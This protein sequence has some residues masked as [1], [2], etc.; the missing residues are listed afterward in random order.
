MTFGTEEFTNEGHSTLVLDRVGLRDAPNLRLIGAYADPGRLLVGEVEGWPPRPSPGF[1][2]PPN[3]EQRQPVSGFRLGPGKT[4][5][6]VIG[7]TAPA[8]PG[9]STSGLVIHYHDRAGSYVLED[10]FMYTVTTHS[11][12]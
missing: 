5:N 12:C 6:M 9:G 1:P 7:V 8:S 3:W 11:Q 2:L 10:H 4:F